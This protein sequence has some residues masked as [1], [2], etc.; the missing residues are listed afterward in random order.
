MEQEGFGE[1][2]DDELS[3]LAWEVAI[4]GKSGR[5]IAQLHERWSKSFESRG[6]FD[7]AQVRR[8]I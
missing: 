5:E 1:D 2:D 8:C 4:R 6:A 3:A 7:A